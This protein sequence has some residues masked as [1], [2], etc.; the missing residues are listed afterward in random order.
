MVNASLLLA[1][2]GVLGAHRRRL[3]SGIGA[4]ALRIEAARLLK[5]RRRLLAELR[6][7][8]TALLVRGLVRDRGVPAVEPRIAAVMGDQRLLVRDDRVAVAQAKL[9]IG[10][11]L[12]GRAGDHYVGHEANR[13]LRLDC[14]LGVAIRPGFAR[15]PSGLLR[16]DRKN[17]REQNSLSH[18]SPPKPCPT[19]FDDTH[20]ANNCKY[21]R[22]YSLMPTAAR[23]I[24]NK[25]KARVRR[26]QV[27]LLC[28]NG[29]LPPSQAY[30]HSQAMIVLFTDF[31]L[32]GPYTG[33]VNAVLRRAAPNTPV[34]QLFADAPAGQAKPSA[35]LLAAYAAWFPAGTLFFC[36]VD[37]GVGGERRPLIA[38]AEGRL[39]VGPDN[40]LF[41]LVLRR[42]NRPSVWEIT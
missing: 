8:D 3:R 15:R 33:Q 18:H 9:G 19:R 38:E 2:E 23:S 21:G 34:I 10:C 29:D 31:G 41:E 27:S 35:Y 24:P 20:L 36:V 39:Y 17:R 32:S 22:S 11:I 5:N 28:N 40:G 7:Q 14:A 6:G 13:L 16:R 25:R 37:P 30:R 4:E 26:P 1:A 12:A 42:A